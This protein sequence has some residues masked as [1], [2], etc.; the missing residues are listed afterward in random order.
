MTNNQEAVAVEA[1][2]AQVLWQELAGELMDTVADCFPR[3]E[4]R[5]TLR[6]AVTGMLMRL[7]RYNCWTLAEALGR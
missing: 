7:D 2:V 4:S 6:E 3:H 1:T 5:R